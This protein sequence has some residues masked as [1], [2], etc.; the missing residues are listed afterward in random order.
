MASGQVLYFYA[1]DQPSCLGDACD[2]PQRLLRSSGGGASRRRRPVPTQAKINPGNRLLRPTVG[3]AAKHVD[4]VGIIEALNAEDEAGNHP[5]AGSDSRGDGRGHAP[6]PASSTV[7]K[8][9]RHLH[10]A[11]T[12]AADGSAGTAAL[13]VSPEEFHR[14]AAERERQREEKLELLR[15]QKHLEE[16]EAEARDAQRRLQQERERA[17]ARRQAKVVAEQM[18]MRSEA[19]R[20][21]KQ[22][23]SLA[24][25]ERNKKRQKAIRAAAQRAAEKARED[26]EARLYH[27]EE[28]RRRKAEE[29]QARQE[30]KVKRMLEREQA[31]MPTESPTDAQLAANPINGHHSP[32]HTAPFDA[33]DLLANT[34]W[35]DEA[36]DF[37]GGGALRVPK[38]PKKA[39]KVSAA[40]RAA[41]KKNKQKMFIQKVKR[42][43]KQIDQL[44]SRATPTSGGGADTWGGSTVASGNRIKD[45]VWDSIPDD[46]AIPTSK[47]QQDINL[48]V[49]QT[50]VSIEEAEA[51]YQQF[52]GDLVN[53]IV[54]FS[55]A[56]PRLHTS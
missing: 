38:K 50:G 49:M 17:A 9:F 33:D 4:S 54:H 55:S 28:A 6:Y 27:A 3:F 23:E 13:K 14:K 45:D 39:R 40:T 11:L 25:A 8:A 46:R 52:N 7:K 41:R 20:Y 37:D 43:H 24:L 1:D 42:G 32:G 51:A 10:E 19:R 47:R 26:K 31:K 48:L 30:E 16:E 12:E 44:L 21:E 2:D 18:K 5:P 56:K 29:E 22:M 36:M 34:A 35:L 53:C 15:R